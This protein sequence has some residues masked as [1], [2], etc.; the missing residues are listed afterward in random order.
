MPISILE[1]MA[2]GIPTISL[3]NS[4]LEELVV[5]N[6]SGYVCEKNPRKIAEKIKDV[7]MNPKGYL[8]LSLSTY[9]YA[10]NFTAKKT[11]EKLCNLYR[12]NVK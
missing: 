5:D 12:F 3:K 1:A 8:D 6:Q 2:S 11:A 9:N 4:G 10:Q 7:S